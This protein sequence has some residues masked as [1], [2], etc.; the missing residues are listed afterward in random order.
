MRCIPWSMPLS[1]WIRI[2]TTII[3][4]TKSP[5][6]NSSKT[7]QNSIKAR[8]WNKHIWKIF[9]RISKTWKSR[10]WKVET[11]LMKILFRLRSLLKCGVS[12]PIRMRQFVP[13]CKKTTSSKISFWK[14]VY[15]ISN[16]SSRAF[17][18]KHFKTSFLSSLKKS[19]RMKCSM[20]CYS[21]N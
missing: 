8:T 12:R 2:Y 15:R 18:L 16:W 1:C 3:W 17:S 20:R 13:N 6:N 21:K 14:K 9:I 19:M 10:V 5:W 4:K 7:A 11:W